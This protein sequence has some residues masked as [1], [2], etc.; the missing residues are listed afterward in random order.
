VLEFAILIGSRCRRGFFSVCIRKRF[1]RFLIFGRK[2]GQYELG[3][4]SPLLRDVGTA[5]RSG[6]QFVEGIRVYVQNA[7]GFRKVRQNTPVTVQGRLCGKDF[8]FEL[9]FLQ[10]L[11]HFGGIFM[12]YRFEKNDD[13]AE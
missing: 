13:R 3:F 6:K 10:T 1:Y 11:L 5:D 12:K 9:F 4:K 2:T 7:H 8:A